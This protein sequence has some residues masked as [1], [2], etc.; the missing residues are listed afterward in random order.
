MFTANIALKTKTQKEKKAFKKFP[1][2][3][4]KAKTKK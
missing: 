3:G 2:L 4:S 1:K